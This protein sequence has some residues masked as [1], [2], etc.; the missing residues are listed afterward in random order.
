MAA[1]VYGNRGQVHEA[2]DRSR[3]A[4][5]MGVL[6]DPLDIAHGVDYLCGPEAR[7]ITGQVLHINAGGVM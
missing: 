2:A 5:P 7:Y 6:L 3:V 1:S 4:N